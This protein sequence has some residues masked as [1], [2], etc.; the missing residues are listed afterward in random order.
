MCEAAPELGRGGQR[1]PNTRGVHDA[2][3]LEAESG[4]CLDYP[5]SS[6]NP[7]FALY[8]LNDE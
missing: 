6:E 4:D 3:H 7:C 5:E 8:S 1:V 2:G